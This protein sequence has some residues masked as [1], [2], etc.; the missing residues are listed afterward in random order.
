M[1]DK[2]ITLIIPDVKVATALEG[3][4][5]SYPNT[6]ITNDIPPVAKYTNAEWLDEKIRRLTIRDIRRG[7]QLIADAAAV[8]AKDDGMVTI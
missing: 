1:A 5:S 7:L 4:L 2:I 3:F 6:E 8:V